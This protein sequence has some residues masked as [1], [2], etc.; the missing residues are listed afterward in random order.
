M[1]VTKKRP[2]KTNKRITLKKIN[3]S[4][5]EKAENFGLETINDKKI[6]EKKSPIQEKMDKLSNN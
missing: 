1:T 5:I 4:I 2:I 3:I 6:I